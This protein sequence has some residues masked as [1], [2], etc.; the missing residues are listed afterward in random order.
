MHKLFAL[1]AVVL[2][3]GC[4]SSSSVLDGATGIIS[5]VIKDVSDVTTY[6]LD[7]ASDAVKAATNTEEK[8]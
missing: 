5:G 6:T 1:V 3:A 4:S 8:E 2:L 7:T